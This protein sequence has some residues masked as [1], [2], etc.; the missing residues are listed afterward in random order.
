[1]TPPAG[2]ASLSGS[3]GTFAIATP[4]LSLLGGSGPGCA[5]LGPGDAMPAFKSVT[6]PD[7]LAACVAALLDVVGGSC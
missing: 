3:M 5:A 4:D 6:D 1:M 7:E 2:G